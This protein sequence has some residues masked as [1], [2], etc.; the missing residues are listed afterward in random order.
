MRVLV[1]LVLFGAVPAFAQPREEASRVLAEARALIASGDDG[2]AYRLAGRALDGS[3]EDVPLLELRL[4]LQQR[5]VGLT[6]RPPFARRIARRRSAERL[7]RLDS[8]S[9]IAHDEIG[10][11][12]LEDYLF[13]RDFIKVGGGFGDV[14]MR[15]GDVLSRNDR[16]NYRP[17]TRTQEVRF[18]RGGR[19]D[20]AGLR[21]TYPILGKPGMEDDLREARRSLNAAVRHGGG[22]YAW[23]LA[24]LLIAEGEFDAL[25]A[26][27]EAQEDDLLRAVA[28]FR[29]GRTREAAGAF[30]VAMAAMTEDER[31]DLDDPARVRP[32]DP[33]R[34]AERFW[35]EQDV[36]LLT[37]E[38]ERLLEHRARVAEADRLFGWPTE[39]GRGATRGEIY[40]RY[41]APEDRA[42]LSEPFYPGDAHVTQGGDVM[43]SPRFVVW[44][45]ADGPRYVF[46]DPYWS[47]D[48][49]I[50]APS[51]LA[52]SA[53]ASA[54]A[55]D[56]IEQDERL[57]RE[58]PDASQYVPPT[59]WP[60]AV[61]TTGFKG[62]N[63]MVD[64]VVVTG[65][66]ADRDADIR[67]AVFAIRDGTPEA[68][69][70]T[71]IESGASGA[72]RT[73]VT[74]LAVPPGEVT[75]VSEVAGED[76]EGGWVRERQ[77]AWDY[78]T[79]LKLSGLLLA[80][81]VDE[82]R[83]P[84]PG[85]IRR[86]DAIIRPTPEAV[87]ASGDPVAVYAEV[88]GL[89]VRDGLARYSVEAALVPDDGRP[90]VV[91][92]IGGL[93]GRGRRRG[94]AVR[95][96]ASSPSADAGI[97]LLLD[98]SRQRPGA[99][100]LTLAVMDEATGETVETARAVTLR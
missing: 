84:E 41:G 33:P 90:G 38:N 71:A 46:T 60:L 93:F 72:T 96:D 74:T 34:D 88:Y 22:T 52:F 77:I 70:E 26:L 55:D 76:D 8:T 3:P 78:G 80:T 67:S 21:A 85:E 12:R 64:L 86:G 87:F 16:R 61:L 19:Y 40:I 23:P 44:E 10:R 2:A 50:Y 31:R 57:R 83:A 82:G 62:A 53:S 6:A 99:Y 28:L 100:T 45:Y 97:P 13:D 56:Y 18:N 42:T 49:A 95:I 7:L 17:G 9:A 94:V 63:G 32:D 36:R 68:M 5:G 14:A 91:Q 75:V 30:D 58:M 4:E 15:H 39:L 79:G 66:E 65:L 54:D 1:A 20:L 27:G 98:A 69:T 35:R 47:G 11:Q 29:L 51:S 37:D 89:R 24:R 92:A 43:G 73:F 25:L 81:S 59:S 48:Y